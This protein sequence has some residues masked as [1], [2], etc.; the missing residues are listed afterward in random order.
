MCVC[1]CVGQTPCSYCA[2]AKRSPLPLGSEPACGGGGRVYQ[3]DKRDIKL[4]HTTV[5]QVDKYDKWRV[6]TRR[7]GALEREFFTDD[8]LVRVHSIIMMSKWTGLAP[9]ASELP[10]P[11]SLIS[12]FLGGAP[13]P[14][15]MLKTRADRK[16]HGHHEFPTPESGPLRADHLSRHK[17]PGGVVD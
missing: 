16:Q 14:A 8:L 2:S 6:R 9:W 15:Q 3:I 5:Y 13:H 4:T 11:G 12:T 7:E 17:W 10:F 1:V